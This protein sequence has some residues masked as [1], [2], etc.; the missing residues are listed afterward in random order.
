MSRLT[1]YIDAVFQ[2]PP[3]SSRFL[4]GGSS[5]GG[6]TSTGERYVVRQYED[7]YYIIDTQSGS[8]IGGPY[9]TAGIAETAL[10]TGSGG[11]QLPGPFNV[12]TPFVPGDV[13]GEAEQTGEI[14]P[15]SL[16]GGGGLKE[17]MVVGDRGNWRIEY[18]NGEV[19][20]GGF[21]TKESAERAL[22]NVQLGVTTPSGA[23]SGG[24]GASGASGGA[25]GGSGGS[26]GGSGGGTAAAPAMTLEEQQALNRQERDAQTQ[27][28]Q[29][30]AMRFAATNPGYR[31]IEGTAR[32]ED[33]QSGQAFEMGYS[34]KYG[35]ELQ[36]AKTYGSVEDPTGRGAVRASGISDM[37]RYEGGNRVVNVGGQS[38]TLTPQMAAELAIATP[39]ARARSLYQMTGRIMTLPEINALL[40]SSVSASGT[41]L[42][43]QLSTYSNAE[44]RERLIA[45]GYD[46]FKAD[47]QVAVTDIAQAAQ[48]KQTPTSF[49][50]G[51]Y[52][53]QEGNK[54]AK[55]DDQIAHSKAQ[56]DKYTQRAL[57]MGYR[58]TG[59]FSYVGPDGKEH[60]TGTTPAALA[61]ALLIQGQFEQEAN[62]QQ[63][64]G[65]P[66]PGQT[67]AVGPRPSTEPR[68]N[69]QGSQRGGFGGI[70]GGGGGG[71]FPRPPAPPVTPPPPPVIGP[72]PAPPKRPNDPTSYV[73]APVYFNRG[74]MV[75]AGAAG[76]A[77][78]Q[79][80][81][82][83]QREVGLV[84]MTTGQLLGVAGEGPDGIG[85]M[86]SPEHISIVNPAMQKRDPLEDAM[87]G[88]VDPKSRRV[89][90]RLSVTV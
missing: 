55:S 6:G 80:G 70:G 76:N 53:D 7:G 19:V 64:A 56:L 58:I 24:T 23:P 35:Y 83:T 65:V 86:T 43:D 38:L 29:N 51:Q 44:Q 17:M 63:Y 16:Q 28:M 48:Q 32:V 26:G 50:G 40:G 81:F 36:S 88:P 87:M 71:L 45:A 3:P 22:E 9:R 31:W 61:L 41:K 5:S 4:T 20:Q 21:S 89:P 66:V 69:V 52:Y 73:G 37:A 11:Q 47:Q 60:N 68:Y 54:I 85:G 25:T 79:Q 72:P 27:E 1:D 30:Q 59:E 84:D 13:G 90:Y 46:P 77:T 2:E 8:R 74:G 18:R 49:S 15:P 14:T 67:R 62:R 82:T 75:T 78:G 10:E 57:G 33:T 39:A 12:Q 34:Q 42:E